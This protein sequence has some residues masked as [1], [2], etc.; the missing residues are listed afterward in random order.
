MTSKLQVFISSTYLDLRQERQAAVEAVLKS[1]HIPAGMELFT[2]GDKSQ[3][4]VI[5]RWIT[6]SDIYMLIL[7]GRYG[8]VENTSGLSYTELEYDFALSLNK[9]H[10]AVVITDEGLESKVKAHG[11][12]V[13]EKDSPEKL[14]RFRAKVL[15]KMSSFFSDYKDVKICVHESLPILAKDNDLKG[16]VRASDIPDTK[17]L[18]DELLKLHSDNKD[19]REKL[20]ANQS[21]LEQQKNEKQSVH[22][23]FTELFDLLSSTM[24]DIGIIKKNIGNA[25]KIP[26]Q[27]SVLDM[28]LSCKDSLLNGVT[29][30]VGISDVENFLYFRLCPKLQ[31][32]ELVADEK[33]AGVR[34]RRYSVTKKGLQFFSFVE[35]LNHKAKAA[36]TK[37]AK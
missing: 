21:L 32:H 14:A 24:I 13:S 23:E 27:V 2:A 36:A 15:E 11:D 18:A 8:S 33:V 28:A 35:K 5:K 31:T 10:F 12:S 16:W 3:W 22:K 1:G 29:N 26:D 6:D 30:Q 4:E 25:S 34:Y 37:P 17:A 7:G 9:P 19:L 20:A